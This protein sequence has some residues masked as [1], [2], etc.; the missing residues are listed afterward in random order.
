M[1]TTDVENFPGFPDGIA[2]PELMVNMRKQA[3]RFGAEVLDK[4]VE[5]VDFS[6]RPLR[7]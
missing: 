2:G 3:Q 5:S 4:D 7:W 1:T 6:T